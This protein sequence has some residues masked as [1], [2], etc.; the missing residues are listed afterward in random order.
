M[1][2]VNG[3]SMLYTKPFVKKPSF[4]FLR[5]KELLFLILPRLC[6]DWLAML[7]IKIWKWLKRLIY[8]SSCR[9]YPCVT[10]LSAQGRN[11]QR[12][13]LKIMGL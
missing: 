8:Q 1:G 2:T 13:S 6:A 11:R 12:Y 10:I 4:H 5:N 7:L 9:R 3:W